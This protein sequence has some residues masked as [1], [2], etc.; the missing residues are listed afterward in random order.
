[1]IL[2][3]IYIDEVNDDDMNDHVNYEVNND[4]VANYDDL[5]KIV[6]RSKPFMY[7]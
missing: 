5:Y 1:M 6:N 7:C 3:I 4:V 2:K